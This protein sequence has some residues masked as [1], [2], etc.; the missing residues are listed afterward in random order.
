MPVDLLATDPARG[1]REARQ[2]EMDEARAARNSAAA[3][4]DG[5]SAE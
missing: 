5:R 1:L 2:I 3:A 4:T